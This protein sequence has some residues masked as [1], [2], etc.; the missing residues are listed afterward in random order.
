MSGKFI[1]LKIRIKNI[2]NVLNFHFSSKEGRPLEFDELAKE[3]E[4]KLASFLPI[5]H[6][7]SEQKIFIHQPVHFEKIFITKDVHPEE[8]EAVKNELEI[9]EEVA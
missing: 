3:K 4:E 5:L 2:F 1:P 6:L 7:S 8:R 9:Y